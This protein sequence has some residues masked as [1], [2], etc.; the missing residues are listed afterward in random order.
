MNIYWNPEYPNKNES[1]VIYVD[2]SD[3]DYF[4][5][6]YQMNIHLSLDGKNYSTYPMYRDYNEGLFV[7]KYEYILDQNIYFQIDNN[8]SFN[9]ISINIIELVDNPDTFKKINL[10]LAEKKYEECIGKLK[11]IINNNF[12]TPNAAKAE[13]MIAEIFLNDFEKYAIAANLYETIISSYPNHYAEVK[14]SMFTLAY[15]Y[16]NYLDYY[17]D[18]ILIYNEFKN[19]Y[20]NDD[21]ISSIDYELQNLTK[22][23]KEI[24]ALLNSSK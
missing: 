5:Y 1:I 13:Y 15:I 2:V 7:W 14:K 16:A 9:N 19:K 17:T 8:Y 12:G 6:S 10:L 20:P 22:I 21:L 18:A 3:T 24:K 4:K 11:N 23:D